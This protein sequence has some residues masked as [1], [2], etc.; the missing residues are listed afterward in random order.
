MIFESRPP[1]ASITCHRRIDRRGVVRLQ[2][3]GRRRGSARRSIEQVGGRGWN[4]SAATATADSAAAPAISARE[5]LDRTAKAYREAKSYA[6]AARVRTKVQL[7]GQAEQD[8]EPVDSIVMFERP[9]K[10][11]VVYGATVLASDGKKLRASVGDPSM[12]GQLLDLD[13]PAKLSLEDLMSGFS[14]PALEEGLSRGPAAFPIQLMLLLS[15]NAQLTE[16]GKPELL[17][18]D[19]YRR[20]SLPPRSRDHGLWPRSV[21]DRSEDRTRYV[22]WN[23]RPMRFAKANRSRAGAGEACE[24]DARI[25]WGAD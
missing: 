19:T 23:C 17:G 22:S 5:L 8:P 2:S 4:A 20:T 3:H 24:H 15:E 6:D 1:I 21:L 11:Q 14:G 12:K 18:D 16:S 9:N 7:A 25:G 10:L 13:A